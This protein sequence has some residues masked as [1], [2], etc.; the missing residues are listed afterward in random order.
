MRRKAM[1]LLYG[2][3]GWLAL[4]ALATLIVS[5]MVGAVMMHLHVQ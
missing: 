3:L 5:Q 2:L 4:V 1:N